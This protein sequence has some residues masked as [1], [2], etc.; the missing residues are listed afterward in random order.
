MNLYRLT[1]KDNE[2][3]FERLCAIETLENAFKMVKKNG[4]AAG[5]DKVTIEEYHK[6]LE[7]NLEQL[8][9][10]HTKVHHKVAH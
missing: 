3:L 5:S 9:R 2:K 6:K 8:L 4:G 1:N 7:G 10:P